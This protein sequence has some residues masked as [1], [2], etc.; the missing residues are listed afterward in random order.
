MSTV[1]LYDVLDL[2]HDC[3]RKE[4]IHSYR[5]LVKQFHPDKPEGDTELFELINHA[6]EILSDKAKRSDYDELYKM[7]QQSGKKHNVLNVINP[8]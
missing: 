4:I 7:S 3:T 1:N 5:K 2:E 6:F 8:S